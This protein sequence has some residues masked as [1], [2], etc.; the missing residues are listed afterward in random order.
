MVG[1]EARF[2]AEVKA[3]SD[4]A[5]G[6]AKVEGKVRS[7]PVMTYPPKEPRKEQDPKP[8]PIDP[9]DD[10]PPVEVPGDPVEQPNV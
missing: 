5:P 4:I 6:T 1:N 10:V 7:S 2:R 9:P 8:D 3:L